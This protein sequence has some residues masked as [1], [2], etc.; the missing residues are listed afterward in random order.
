MFKK[1]PIRNFKA[2][3]MIESHDKMNI[4]TPYKSM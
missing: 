3:K 2:Q 1:K 4:I